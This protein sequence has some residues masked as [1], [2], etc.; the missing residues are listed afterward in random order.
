RLPVVDGSVTEIEA[1]IKT[2]VTADKVN[3]AI[4]KHAVDIP[5]VG[6]DD[7]QIVSSE[8]IGTTQGS[9]FDPTQTEVTTAGDIQLAKT[10]AW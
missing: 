10:V 2:K 7:R 1:V 4:K 8:V 5:S 9:I 6:Y 3:E